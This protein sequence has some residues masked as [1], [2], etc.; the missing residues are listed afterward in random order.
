M[1]F[2][3]LE[4]TT[5]V[6]VLQTIQMISADSDTFG[7]EALQF[8]T[9]APTSE[10]PAISGLGTSSQVRLAPP[11]VTNA[12]HYDTQS[13]QAPAPTSMP[14]AP[15]V[16]Q[17]LRG[18]DAVITA[19][20]NTNMIIIVAKP[21]AQRMY[22][23]LI[24]ML[25]KR[26]PQVLIECTIV[27]LD[28]TNNFSFGVEIAARGGGGDTSVI[29]FSSFGLS[30]VGTTAGPGGDLGRLTL[31]PGL[32]FN[33]TL[34]QSDIAA[35]VIKALLTTGRAEV[36]SAPKILVNDNT[37]GSLTSVQEAPFTSV[38]ASNTVATTAF[39][40]Y[41]SA[42]TTIAVTPHLSEGDS[43][44]LEYTVSLNSFT[45]DAGSAG[46]P[47]PRQ[48]NQLQSKVTIPDG[49]TIVVGGLN[50]RNVSHT[51]DRIPFLGELP[52]VQYFFS[53]RSNQE[54]TSTLFVFIRP[55]VLRDDK[56]ADLKFLSRRDAQAAGLKEECPSSEP[57][58]SR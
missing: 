6:D 56:F 48:T 17:T 11:P 4:N 9:P 51:V 43:L 35:V 10:A 53:S 5:A 29:G 52:F 2:Y 18:K 58:I 44:Q 7:G 45:G 46:T 12:P 26:R 54:T 47:P 36:V 21:D 3:K 31:T 40:G 55:V 23:Q 49:A 22:E 14:A 33:G 8:D 20:P 38:N 28:T 15:A 50:R 24:H 39:A 27:T 1:R 42:G 32:G 19:D 30:K 37:T 16:R 25:D 41:A 13:Q 57:L 34:I